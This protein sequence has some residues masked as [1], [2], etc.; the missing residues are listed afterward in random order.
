[1]PAPDIWAVREKAG[2]FRRPRGLPVQLTAGP[3]HFWNP[4]PS[5]D[6]KVIFAAST[7]N[8]GELMRYD[9]KARALTPYLAEFSVQAVNFSRD[10][11]WMTYVTFP[12][13]ELWRSRSDGSEPLQLT[14][15]PLIVHDPHWSP[16]GK[17]IV[18]S[19]LKAGA[20]W[21]LYLVSRDGSTSQRLLPDS[22]AGI[23]PTWSADG[24]SVLFA[25]PPSPDNTAG[26]KILQELDLQTQ[27]VSVVPGSNGLR[28]SRFS[29]DGKYI[30]AIS[31]KDEGLVLFNVAAQRW[32]KQGP[33]NAGWQCWSRDSK[34]IYFLGFGA[35]PGIFRIAVNNNLEK[36]LSLKDFRPAGTF[37]ASLSLTPDDDPLVLRDV[38]PPEIYA[39]TWEAP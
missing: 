6:G 27:R 38:G 16:D 32:I 2:W 35:E 1:M 4:I 34:Y 18:Y 33:K 14:Y 12:Q 31:A 11:A 10:G 29:P 3:L 28:A 7:S 15:S 22:V 17:Q 39:L 25:Q 21:Q 30:S 37:G 13:G 9:R 20:P 24:K 5:L 19:G 23:D 26:H 8:R 36:I